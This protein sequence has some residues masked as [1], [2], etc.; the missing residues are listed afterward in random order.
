MRG[1]FV[2]ELWWGRRRGWEEAHDCH[3]QDLAEDLAR[4]WRQ[5]GM[6]ARVRVVSAARP[7][8]TTRCTCNYFQGVLKV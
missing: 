3:G 4:E 6:P 8:S 5:D 7:C 1:K 2:V